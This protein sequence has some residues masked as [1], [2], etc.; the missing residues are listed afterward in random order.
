MKPASRFYISD[1]ER[2]IRMNLFPSYK[3]A[4]GGKTLSETNAGYISDVKQRLEEHGFSVGKASIMEPYFP[5]SIARAIAMAG[6]ASLCALAF[7]LIFPAAF[8]FGYVIEIAVLLLTQGLFWLTHSVLPLQMLALG[9][10][11]CTPVVVVSLFLEY[12]IKQKNKASPKSAGADS[13]WNPS[14]FCGLQEF[15]PL[16]A[17]CLSAAFSGTSDS[18]WRCR[19]SGV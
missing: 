12:C 7:V 3:F 10:A 8:K 1:I 18:C 15:F 13:S 14:L 19:F 16:S 6:A 2:N 17:P 5:N 11:V 4:A 9:C